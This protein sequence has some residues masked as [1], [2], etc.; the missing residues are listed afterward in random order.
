MAID[1][2]I[3]MMNAIIN[4]QH[5]SQANM[6]VTH[7]NNEVIVT[8]HGHKI[9]VVN[10]DKE[11]LYISWCGH[12]TPSTTKLIKPIVQHFLG[13]SEGDVKVQ[14]IKG[15][16]TITVGKRKHVFHDDT[17]IC[18]EYDK[19]VFIELQNPSYLTTSGMIT[20]R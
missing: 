6:T 20:G 3:G 9:A 11:E 14:V 10:L 15:D 5:F 13:F 7:H 4:K 17:V 18:I 16:P 12:P 19:N 1:K 2:V 8:L